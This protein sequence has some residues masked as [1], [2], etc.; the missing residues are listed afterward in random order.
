MFVAVGADDSEG[1]L[2]KSHSIST[3]SAAGIQNWELPGK[4]L[5]KAQKI[6]GRRIKLMIGP[7]KVFGWHSRR[8]F[9]TEVPATV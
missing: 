8:L 4:R 5:R 6:E 9:A 2:S 7:C 1:M 3:E